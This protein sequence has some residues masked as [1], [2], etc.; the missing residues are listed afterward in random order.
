MAYGKENDRVVRKGIFAAVY[1]LCPFLYNVIGK[2]QVTE[3][4][5]GD[6]VSR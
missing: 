5:E 1:F 6:Y 2:G 3:N 4:M